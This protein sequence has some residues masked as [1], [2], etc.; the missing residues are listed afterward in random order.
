MTFALSKILWAFTAP[1]NLLILILVV[2]VARLHLRRRRGRS[3]VTLAALGFV[4]IAVLPCG[5]WLLS[6][7]EARFPQPAPPPHVDGVILL[8][9]AVESDRAYADEQI[10]LN[11]A[12]ER[13]V[14]F[15]R[16]ARHYPEARLLVSGGSGA[17]FPGG[18]SEAED[19]RTLLVQQGIAPD[20]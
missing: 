17:L 16:L 6:P 19:T 4:A 8:G 7:L 18:E 12:A 5:D 1:A 13:V 20:R 3:L 2:G 10:A 14:E 15:L 11:G 9:G